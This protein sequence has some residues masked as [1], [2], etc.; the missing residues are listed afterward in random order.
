[1]NTQQN[2]EIKEVILIDDELNK[3]IF[4]SL[5]GNAYDIA[6]V[7]YYINKNLYNYGD[8]SW[9]YFNNHIW[10][11]IQSPELNF[12][13]FISDKLQKIYLLFCIKNIIKLPAVNKNIINILNKLKY[14]S[15]KEKII[16]E[17]IMLY[18]LKYNNNFSDKLDK[19]IHLLGFNNGVY[20]LKKF[21]FRDGIP[22]DF[23]SKSVGYDYIFYDSENK[24]IENTEN[25]SIMVD[26]NILDEKN[27]IFI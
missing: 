21:V 16:N 12:Y 11:K 4:D 9:Y 26:S 22:N 13:I 6:K 27:T 8:N 2:D 3:L 18:K 23:I 7:V 5:N 10:K 17:L 19:N 1:M 20:D 15:F 25:T 24:N 14:I